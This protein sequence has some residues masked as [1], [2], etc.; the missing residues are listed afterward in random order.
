ML[1]YRGA[2]E[3][4]GKGYMGRAMWVDLS[5]GAI[6]RESV[7]DEIY[8]KFLTGYG[9]GAKML[10]DRI[11]PGA[12]PLGP[13][14]IL[15][16]CSGLLTGTPSL[17]TG[18]LEVVCKSPLTGGWGDA[19]CGGH[20][21]PAI[22]RAGVDAIFLAG[23]SPGPVYLAVDGEHASLRDASAIWGK[24][25]VETERLV[26]RELGDSRGDF[27][28]A[29]VGP[30]GEK[31]VRFAGICHDGGRYAA[32][33]GVGA[34]MGSK[35]LKAV[36]VRGSG[37]VEVH[38][39]QAMRSLTRDFGKAL[40][41]AGFVRNLLGSRTM[42]WAGTA[43][44]MS[45]VAMAQAGLLWRQIL[46]KYGTM[47]VTAMSAE[48]GDSPVK[49]W[50]GA[51]CFDF[52]SSRASRIADEAVLR[53][54]KRRYACHS[55]PVACGGIMEVKEGP[56]PLAETHKPEYETLAALGTLCLVDDLPALFKLNDL[57]NRGGLD[58]ISAGGVLAFAIECAERGILTKRD[59][60][61]LDLG[62]GKAEAMI[63]L[64][65]MI[66]GRQGIG[67]VLAEGVA[68]AAARIG[69]GAE[70]FAVHAGG[71]ELPMH[72]PRLDPGYGLAYETEPTPGRHTIASFTWQE[73]MLI[74]RYSKDA[75]KVKP[76]QS[77]GGRLSP[78]GKAR[79]QAINSKVMQLVNSTGVCLF[80]MSCG[81]RLPLYEY[82][83]AATGWAL[84]EERCLEIGERI[85][86]L[87]HAF[88]LREG[89]TP[90]QARMH[91]RG[92]GLPP[93]ERGPHRGVTLD[94]D[95][96]AREYRSE[97][98][99]DAD[100]GMPSKRRLEELGLGEAVRALFG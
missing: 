72:D 51:G 24:D 71:Q 94:T 87:R 12:D 77:R 70:E 90:R 66:I 63:R 50:K 34:V 18:R 99:W 61:G 29:A 69:R 78:F 60:G 100:T 98:G 27:K 64:L 16:F 39:G 45:P 97:F 23:V 15:G 88:N 84:D 11:Q 75:V 26:R 4:M 36:A 95:A 82:I 25:A 37:A 6:L 76:V 19:N 47:G 46:Q 62:W 17:F 2:E 89:I 93:L 38:D 28:V 48:S 31:L 65:E 42:Q 1:S 96:M 32:R 33:S 80:G 81:P 35:R 44:R 83:N 41:Q 54:Q 73:L 92:R 13:G 58:T 57:C 43:T 74:D 22:K 9:L 21:S 10:F 59:L 67:D 5:K 79:N 52:P 14:N 8:R 68:R 7:P 56:W 55:C 86:N 40:K 49:N 91:P 30:A 53:F 85:Q 3:S 20:L